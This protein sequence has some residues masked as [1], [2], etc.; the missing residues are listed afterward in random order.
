MDQNSGQGEIMKITENIH[1]ISS[2]LK[3]VASE[4]V[5]SSELEKEDKPLEEVLNDQKEKEKNEKLSSNSER[6]T[7]C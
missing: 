1:I 4:I 5:L 2:T 6:T 7:I 3:T